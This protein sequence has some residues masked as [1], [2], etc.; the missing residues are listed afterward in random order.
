MPVRYNISSTTKHLSSILSLQQANLPGV[1]TTKEKL[2]HGFVTVEHDLDLLRKMNDASPH[3]IALDGDL[4]IGYALV[5]LPSFRNEI[6]VL[7]PMF[8]QI[9]KILKQKNQNPNY[10]VMGQ[11]CIKKEYRGMGVFKG[12]YDKMKSEFSES[13]TYCITEVDQENQRSLRAHYKQ[14]FKRLKLYAGEG[15]KMWELIIW[16]WN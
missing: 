15:N 2:D 14:G 7:K 6:E 1:L 9:D 12:L 4:V 5:M 8:D 16:D 13:Y 11:V 10:F 3:V